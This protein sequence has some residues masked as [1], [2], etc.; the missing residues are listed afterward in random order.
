MTREFYTIRGEAESEQDKVTRQGYER[1]RKESRN[2]L[3]DTEIAEIYLKIVD[4]F[5]FEWV[6]EV[7]KQIY[8]NCQIEDKFIEGSHGKNDVVL[9][10]SEKKAYAKYNQILNTTFL[11]VP[12]IERALNELAKDN[13]LDK[14]KLRALLIQRILIHEFVH[15]HAKS[16]CCGLENFNNKKSGDVE[17]ESG[18]S[19]HLI[20]VGQKGVFMYE[21]EVK[22]M[23][24]LNEGV[25]DLIASDIFDRFLEREGVKNSEEAINF[26]QLY[27][28]KVDSYGIHKFAVND[29]IQTIAERNNLSFKTAYEALLHQ[30]FVNGP[31]TSELS[32]WIESMCGSAYV[33]IL[34][35]LPV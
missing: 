1:Y 9:Y 5:P 12:A 15:A 27:D 10:E 3:E 22:I 20:P 17:L 14:T 21:Y 23:E 32:L 35:K 30:Y 11:Y 4:A 6:D 8:K 26:I 31:L 29:L 19:S 7:F 16:R 34:R 25:T 28:T 13:S 33:D 24:G 2:Y 18:L